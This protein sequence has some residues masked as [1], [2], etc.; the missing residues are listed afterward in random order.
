MADNRDPVNGQFIKIKTSNTPESSAGKF[1]TYAND[2]PVSDQSGADWPGAEMHPHHRIAGDTL[3]G[4]GPSY[5]SS[6]LRARNPELV[7]PDDADH[8]VYGT[9]GAVLRTA[10]RSSGPDDPSAYLV[11]GTDG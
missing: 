2:L 4:T 9:Q 7:H 1:E 3:A 8:E 5:G 10:A 6:P 11:R